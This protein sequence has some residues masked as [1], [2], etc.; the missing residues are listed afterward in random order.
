MPRQKRDRATKRRKLTDERKSA[1]SR[2]HVMDIYASVFSFLSSS[3]PPEQE[4]TNKNQL[5]T[6]K[7]L[8]KKY[9]YRTTFV[10][11]V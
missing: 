5:T 7:F 9:L 4:M 10:A 1:L 6:R 11:H 2:D 3:S 8:K